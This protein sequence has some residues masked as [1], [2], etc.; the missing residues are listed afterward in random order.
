MSQYVTCLAQRKCYVLLQ[1]TKATCFWHNRFVY[2]DFSHYRC[3]SVHNT[4]TSFIQLTAWP[5]DVR[6]CGRH[7][8]ARSTETLASREFHSKWR[9]EGI[10]GWKWKNH[11][12]ITNSVLPSSDHISEPYEKLL[13]KSRGLRLPW[14][15]SDWDSVL[16]MQGAWVWSLVRELNPTWRN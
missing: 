10:H 6:P 12:S 14:W 15:S 5:L 13:G 2:S 11:T 1:S 4:L 8:K 7:K 9:M 16:P 3:S